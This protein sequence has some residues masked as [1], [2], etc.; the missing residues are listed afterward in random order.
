MPD[1]VAELA[2]S[3]GYSIEIDYVLIIRNGHRTA[4]EVNQRVFYSSELPHAALQRPRAVIAMHAFDLQCLAHVFRAHF[5]PRTR[6]GSFYFRSTGLRGVEFHKQLP[7]SII[8]PDGTDAGTRNHG[9]NGEIASFR[10][11]DDQL[12]HRNATSGRAYYVLLHR[13]S[14]VSS[15]AA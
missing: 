10:T 1:F 3:P 11:S 6:H 5:F 7:G 13:A 15:V 9:L 8:N 2:H 12:A 4:G 14:A